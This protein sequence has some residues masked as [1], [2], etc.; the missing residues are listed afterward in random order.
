MLVQKNQII[1]GQLLE[2]KNQE[3]LKKAEL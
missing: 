2:L 1:E 3:D